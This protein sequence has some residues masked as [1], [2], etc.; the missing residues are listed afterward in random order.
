MLQKQIIP[1]W[2]SFGEYDSIY[3]T[4]DEIIFEIGDV[5]SNHH[6]KIELQ[7]ISNKIKTSDSSVEKRRY[8]KR[9]FKFIKQIGFRIIIALDEFDNAQKILSLQD[10]QF[11][12]I[13]I[14]NHESNEV[15]KIQCQNH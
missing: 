12:I 13:P 15:L 11:L 5:L 1:I 4:L 8:I 10:F 14:K 9:Y 3:E 2:I 7:E 6:T